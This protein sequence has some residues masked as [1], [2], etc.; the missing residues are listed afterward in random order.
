MNNRTVISIAGLIVAIIAGIFVPYGIYSCQQKP[1]FSMKISPNICSLE[2]GA[3]KEAKIEIKSINGYEE[4]IALKISDGEDFI[5]SS[6][7]VELVKHPYD[8]E[9]I[10]GIETDRD[11]AKAGDYDVKVVGRGED[12]KERVCLLTLTIKGEE[13]KDDDEKEKDKD[14][15]SDKTSETRITSPVN[16]QTIISSSYYAEG[17]AADT[18]PEGKH[19]WLGLYTDGNW[20]P[21][22]EITPGLGIWGRTVY[23]G[24]SGAFDIFIIYLNDQENLDI[25]NFIQ[26]CEASGDWPGKALPVN[27]DF[28]DKIR[29]NIQK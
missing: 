12:N 10:L 6:S 16:G 23:F 21:Q 22:M 24:S 14:D 20:W 15:G 13:E 8:E 11:T 5:V 1:D 18:L 17:T 9:I 7:S 27:A 29:V 4:P 3:G 26:R 19:A 28:A 25:S 2:K